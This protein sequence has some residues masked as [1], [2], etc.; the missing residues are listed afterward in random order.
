MNRRTLCLS[1]W[2]LAFGG[3]GASAQPA[4]PTHAVRLVVAFPAGGAADAAARIVAEKL[5]AKW[6][7]PVIVDNRPGAAGAVGTEVVVK[8]LPD[9]HTALLN[10]STLLV[11]EVTKP[12]AAFRLFRDL[13]PVTTLFTTP[14]LFAVGEGVKGRTLGEVM[15]EAKAAG[16]PFSYGHHGDGTSTHLMG[17]RLSRLAGAQMVA[18][19]YAGDAPMSNDLMGGHLS[20]GFSSATNAKK[21]VDSGKVRVVAQSFQRRSPLF[22][23]IPTFHE[24]GY[25]EMDR[26]T[27]GRVFLPAGAPEAVAVQFSAAIREALQM[28]D[29]REKFD[30]LGLVPG[31]GTP[32]QTLT[33]LQGD[34]AY[35]QSRQREIGR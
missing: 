9:G 23:D 17:E 28:K 16:K 32:E 30:A 2:A 1:A 25:E 33:E 6:K 20:A 26:G 13:R 4:F 7:Q 12:P 27:W 18:V 35:W 34:Y 21:L 31:G 19:P 8:S 29:V 5:S 22:P 3:V 15:R 14:V 10:V 11:N 24:L